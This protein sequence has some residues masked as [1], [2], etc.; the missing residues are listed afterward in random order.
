MGLPWANLLS[1]R[2]A[3]AVGREVPALSCIIKLREDLARLGLSHN[4]PAIAG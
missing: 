2:A 1:Y 4:R 3:K